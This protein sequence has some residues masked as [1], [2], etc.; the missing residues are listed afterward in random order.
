MA[1]VQYMELHL[2]NRKIKIL[3]NK[4][5]VV[6]IVSIVVAAAAE[7]HNCLEHQM[8]G[9]VQK[10]L[11]VKSYGTATLNMIFFFHETL[12]PTTNYYC[13]CMKYL[14]ILP[15]SNFLIKC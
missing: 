6:V 2:V 15:I 13:Q 12:L 14:Y 9:H 3:F 10:R 4:I 5:V 7:C 1:P 11:Q 8:I